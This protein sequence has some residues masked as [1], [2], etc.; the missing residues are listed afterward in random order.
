MIS[1][2]FKP[3]TAP[4]GQLL[5]GSIVL[6]LLGERNGVDDPMA[7]ELAELMGEPITELKVEVFRQI[8]DYLLNQREPFI[9]PL[10]L[11]EYQPV[12]TELQL[13]AHRLIDS[14]FIRQPYKI[15]ILKQK[16]TGL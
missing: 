1:A 13:T 12:D 8:A 11:N 16:Q 3:K 15:A 7:Q 10:T 9:R 2:T 5:G 14:Q 4:R 6:K